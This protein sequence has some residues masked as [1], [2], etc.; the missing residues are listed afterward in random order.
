MSNN[1][2]NVY[3]GIRPMRGKFFCL[4]VF[5]T[6]RFHR[7]FSLLSF[8]SL[9]I[10][11]LLNPAFVYAASSPWTQT[12]W[13]GGSGQTAWSDTAKF[14]S[15]S[16]INTASTSG[17]A[18][19]SIDEKL[20][21]T[22]FTTNNTS[23]SVAAV[24]PSGW[25]EVPANSTY[26]TSNFLVMKYEAKCAA[27][28]D[29]TTGLTSPNSGSNTYS[30]SG[31]N[32][33]SGSSKAVVSVASGYPIANITQSTSSTRC[34]NVTLNSN[35]SHLITNN[36]W[37]TIARNAEAQNSNWTNGTVGSGALFSGHN[38]NSPT[39]ALVAS[40]DDSNGY[41]GTGNSASSGQ[42]RTLTL[43][44][45][46][47]IWD[48]SGNIFEWLSDTITDQANQPDSGTHAGSFGSTQFTALTGYGT[49]SY[50]AIRPANS[51]YNSSQGMGIIYHCDTC[52]SNATTYA[53]V[54]SAHW[55]ST[56]QAGA[57]TLALDT[58]PSTSVSYL[59]FRC[60]SNAVN[61]SQT[62]SSSSGR[63]GGGDTVAVGSISDAKLY[64]SVNVGDTSTY[65]FSAYVYDNT[66]G[67]EG[68]TVS[69]SIAQLYYNGA[70]VSTAYTN[71]GSGW[72]K[73][74]GT[75]TGVA[76]SVDAGLLVKAGK[77]VKVDD[78]S[79]GNYYSSGTLT[80]SIFDSGQG[81]NWG[82]LTYT[83]TT[84][85]NTS[86]TVK[87]RTSNDSGMSG[88]TAFSSCNAIT[89]ASDISSNNCVTDTHRYI[90]YQLALSTTSVTDSTPTFS[91]IS[92]TFEVSD[93]TAPSISL[94]ALS[95]DPSTDSTPT[96]SGTATESIG[97]VSN[98]QF[99]I[100]STSGSWS[101]CTADDASFDEASETFTCT[102]SALSDGSH[103]MYVRATDS[104]GNTTG[105]G[106]ESS[107]SF[108][109]DTT[110]PV[111]IDLDSPGNNSYTNSERPIFRWKATTDATAGLSKYVLEIDNPSIGSS[112]PSGDFTIDNIPTSRTTDYETNKYLIHYEN[113]SDSDS[114]NNY[115]SIYTKS[116]SDWG[117]SENDGKL[118][119][120]KVSWKIKAIDNAGNE[121]SS[122]RTLFIDYLAPTLK[123][124]QVNSKTLIADKFLTTDDKPTVFGEITDYLSGADNDGQIKQ[125]ENGPKAASGP[126]NIEIKI[127][128]ENN[129]GLY[130]LHTLATVV[131]DK[132][133]WTVD[134]T[135]ITDNSK[136]KSNKYSTFSFSPYENLS[137]GIYKITGIGKDN[138]G[139]STT[140]VFYLTKSISEQAL[141]PQQK[142]TI[143]QQKQKIK[144]KKDIVKPTASSISKTFANL[145]A[146]PVRLGKS[147]AS[148]TQGV[149][150]LGVDAAKESTKAP[151]QFISRFGN[152]VSYSAI[153]FGEIVLD[154]KSTQIS[155]VRIE[156]ATA[157]TATIYWKTN[158]LAT[159]KVNYG[160]TK[161]YGDDVQD[162][163]KVHEHRLKITG[164]NPGT[165][166][167]YE[168]M[169][170]GKN[171]VYDANHEFTTP[172]K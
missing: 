44:N 54:R 91:D 162:D 133:Y 69:S 127:E 163:S 16:N 101:S 55:A 22:T 63:S 145:I 9:I 72:W 156:K 12:D 27:T 94:T 79:L 132:T 117:D 148:Y 13:S 74:S 99:Q 129:L 110:T 134:G 58:T 81:S 24:P 70:A 19:I 130:D 3:T 40:S 86:V 158:H 96:L 18:T 119:E 77:T 43:S 154:S 52:S 34:T 36:E 25:V 35:A 82:T 48:F 83:A 167:H 10:N 4:N 53:L 67:S 76:S 92:I 68:G 112:Q 42:K 159:S 90:Q 6:L 116:H 124:T 171:Y 15:S 28:S 45:S 165:T 107:D 100:D 149:F 38:D 157:T 141:A 118:R 137:L 106:S 5:S 168:V 109:I 169:S 8:F 123:L 139:N 125:D 50:D 136:N 64:Q 160:I 135:E 87:A 89:S 51:S 7:A 120:G 93:A 172:E 73:L 151:K 103:T 150:S 84:P 147:L 98:V 95:P 80:S 131:I 56:T 113:F 121:T 102:S 41:S 26:S 140:T 37:M 39:T 155:D 62:Y 20:N 29:L 88:A 11:L 108:T 146:I 46:A 47:V 21:N 115:I 1:L 59:G 143:Q 30:D 97:T 57:F 126:K 23:W 152:W 161:D 78:F 17:Q 2:E 142:K 114:T 111:S 60:A 66:S 65:G 144:Q 164:L 71:I 85:S 153:S 166:Y 14:D 31:T 75:I 122:S 61:I 33:I 49:L 32:C 138:A 170:Q 105:S 128:K 104:N